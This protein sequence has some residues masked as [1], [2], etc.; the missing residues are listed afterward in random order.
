[1]N[2]RHM[3][4]VALRYPRTAAEAFRG[5]DYADP[6]DRPPGRSLLVSPAFWIGGALSLAL[7]LLAWGIA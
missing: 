6:I 4:R 5:P 2:S 7:W 3:H 1:M